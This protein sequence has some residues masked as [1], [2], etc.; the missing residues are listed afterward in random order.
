MFIF[1]PVIIT[2]NLKF[3]ILKLYETVSKAMG[4]PT[5]SLV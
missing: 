5:S 4:I 3:K 1:Q 2:R